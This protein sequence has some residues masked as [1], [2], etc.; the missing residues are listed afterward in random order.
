MKKFI[1]FVVV[2]FAFFSTNSFALTPEEEIVNSVPQ[3]PKPAEI[4]KN[5]GYPKKF[6]DSIEKLDKKL[7][8]LEDDAVKKTLSSSKSKPAPQKQRNYQEDKAYVEQGLTIMQQ[9]M[10]D[11]D[12]TE[13]DIEKI[14]KMNDAESEKFIMNRMK[15]KG[16]NPE[17]YALKGVTQ[18][19]ATNSMS[20]AD[21]Q[22]LS[23]A[24]QATSD[25]ILQRQETEKKLVSL[26]SKVDDD[27]KKVWNK[28][29]K[30]IEELGNKIAAF[31]TNHDYKD[32]EKDSAKYREL[33][34][35]YNE[36]AYQ[37]YLNY[38]KE[39]QIVLKNLLKYAVESDIA[40]NNKP[41]TTGINSVSTSAIAV[42]RKYIEITMSSPQLEIK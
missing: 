3:L 12:L 37:V 32:S 10:V 22:A 39:A 20:E 36:E 25:L 40:N 7:D 33:I 38:I 42:V 15:Q 35:K 41:N 2:Y 24:Q 28:H 16:I 6:I 18:P 1:Y 21:M 29:K 27:L 8:K 31:D 11:L 5:N 19:P 17:K 30:G 34:A 23:R 14:S 13:A 9:M 26:K 4:V